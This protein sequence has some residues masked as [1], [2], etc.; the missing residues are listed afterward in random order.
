MSSNLKANWFYYEENIRT[1]KA[2]LQDLA[3]PTNKYTKDQKS[4]TR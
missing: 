2:E 4:T 1:S 3:S